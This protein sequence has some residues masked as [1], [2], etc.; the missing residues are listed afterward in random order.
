MRKASDILLGAWNRYQTDGHFQDI[1][2]TLGMAGIAAGGQ[3]LF[4]DMSPEEIAFSTLLGAGAGLA[5][6]PLLARGGYALG[7]QI[8]KRIPDAQDYGGMLSL[9]SPRGREIYGKILDEV[10][11]KNAAN[12]DIILKLLE[13]KGNQNYI[14]P[15]GT[16]RGYVEGFLGGFGRNRGDN[17]AQGAVALTTP[18]IFGGEED[19]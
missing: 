14:R 16:P 15:D 1:V 2:E 8:D 7:R 4:T 18:F 9:S 13:A 11:G 10:G 6:R 3:A 5:A 17:L 19:A 12:K